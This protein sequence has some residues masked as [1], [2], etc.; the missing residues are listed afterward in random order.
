MKRLAW[1]LDLQVL[2]MTSSRA[3]KVRMLLSGYFPV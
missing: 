1:L 2:I 3:M